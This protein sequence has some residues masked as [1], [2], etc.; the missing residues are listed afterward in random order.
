MLCFYVSAEQQAGGE[1]E[2]GDGE[3][4]RFGE[5]AHSDHEG[6]GAPKGGVYSVFELQCV[7]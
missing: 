1:R 6:G 5:E 4:F 2:G 7:E 3:S